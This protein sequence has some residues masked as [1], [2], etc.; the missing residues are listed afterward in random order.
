MQMAFSVGFFP[1][2]NVL[3]TLSLPLG[4]TRRGILMFQF[5]YFRKPEEA[6]TGCLVL[7]RRGLR[8]AEE[9]LWPRLL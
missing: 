5:L 4:R 1:G 3:G 8:R 6:A 9:T 7:G 2:L